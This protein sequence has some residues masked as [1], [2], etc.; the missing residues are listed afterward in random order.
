LPR[1]AT[2]DISVEELPSAR[3]DELEPLW[4]SLREHHASVAPNWL[5]QPRKRAESWA[6]RRREYQDW[7]SSGADAFVLVARR[8]GRA[9]AYAMAHLGD[10]SATFA[11]GER[12]G[13]VETL[14]V[15]PDER[16]SGV[17]MLLLDAVRA[18]L[19]RLGAAELSIHV[20]YGNDAAL[21]FYRR[22][23]LRPFAIALTGAVLTEQRPSRHP[24]NTP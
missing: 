21:R 15:L 9:V 20:L 18:R 4:N 12:A 2:A 8:R 19:S 24:R 7:L 13:A 17:G 22:A 11:S 1:I 5:G 23:G 16:G 10:G 6:R 3:L 14:C